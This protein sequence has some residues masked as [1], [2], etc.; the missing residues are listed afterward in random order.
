MTALWVVPSIDREWG[1]AC[2]AT[3][4]APLVLRIDNAPPNENRG[5]AQSW[6]IAAR[7]AQELDV[8]YLIVCSEACRF[9]PAGGLDFEGLLDGSPIVLSMCA[10]W[11]LVALSVRALEVTGAFDENLWPAYGEDRDYMI[12]LHLAGLPSPGYND[13]PISQHA[14]D[15]V[16][17][18]VAHSLTTGLVR[19]SFGAMEDYLRAKWGGVGPGE[20]YQHPFDDTE[21]DWRWWPNALDAHAAPA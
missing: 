17:V 13:Q 5:V 20:H 4:R 8:D 12:R 19:V 1:D 7:V 16:E 18:G 3:L 14:V 6:N 2:L 21:R 9:G 10:G 15:V 11:H